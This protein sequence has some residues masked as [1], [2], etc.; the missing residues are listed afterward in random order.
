MAKSFLASYL[1]PCKVWVRLHQGR[2]FASFS[3]AYWPIRPFD[4]TQ[5]LYVL[6][7]EGEVS[8]GARFRLLFNKT[9]YVDY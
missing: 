3:S 7:N 5:N 2:G 4:Y 6:Q 8:P 9:S 1:Y